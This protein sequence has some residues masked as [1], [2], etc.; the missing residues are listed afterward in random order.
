MIRHVRRNVVGYVA[1]FVALGGTSYAATSLP[2]GSV[3][4]NQLKNGAVTGA[5]VKSKSLTASDFEANSLPAGPKGATGPQGETG[6]VGPTGATGATGA[7]GPMGATGATGATGP[8]GATGPQ[9]DTGAT[10]VGGFFA[11]AVADSLPAST[12]SGT[13]SSAAA[14]QQ[15]TINLP[16]AGNLVVLDPDVETI[17]YRNTSGSIVQYPG[18]S[19]YLDGN[20]VPDSYVACTTQCSVNPGGYQGT[21]SIP[22]PDVSI[23]DVP[24][25]SHTVTLALVLGSNANYLYASAARLAVL[26]SAS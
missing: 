21:G 20:P 11:S 2:S 3:G 18:F 25:G 14:I 12:A 26:A 19:L 10:G 16:D 4:T 13:L 5:K 15:V 6:A 23:P 9:G 22:L 7:V 24:A 1:L 17:E 8:A